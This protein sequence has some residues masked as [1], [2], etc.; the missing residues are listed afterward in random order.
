MEEDTQKRPPSCIKPPQCPL[1]HVSFRFSPHHS[2]FLIFHIFTLPHLIATMRPCGQRNGSLR[3]RGHL[4]VSSCMQQGIASLPVH[5]YFVS[6]R[7]RSPCTSFP[8]HSVFS[9]H[10][11]RP[12][13]R[14][15][16]FR[17]PNCFGHFRGIPSCILS[18]PGLRWVSYACGS[19]PY[20][21]FIFAHVVPA[22][23]VLRGAL[24]IPLI[25]VA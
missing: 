6:G 10:A 9:L 17:M 25:E 11:Q 12:I 2:T 7:S 19:C 21:A 20:R 16:A 13:P 22:F 5:I 23:S 4:Q 15:G 18:P 8:P 14:Y 1:A 3:A 24:K